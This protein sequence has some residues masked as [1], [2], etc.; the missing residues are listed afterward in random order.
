MHRVLIF[1]N[2]FNNIKVLFDLVNHI[3]YSDKIKYEVY[4]TTQAFGDL[5]NIINYDLVIV[6]IKL[7]PKSL[8]DGYN[9]LKRIEELKNERSTDIPKVIVMTGNLDA[10]EELKQRGMSVY[11]IITKPV[12]LK[13]LRPK[14]ATALN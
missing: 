12:T 7:A 4:P 14:L 6:D 10:L 2:E 9:L 1:E 11:P 3:D 8:L 13:S 5:R